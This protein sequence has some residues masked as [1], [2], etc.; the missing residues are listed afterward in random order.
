MLA[1]ACQ[2]LLGD[3][4]QGC[5]GAVVAAQQL[6]QVKRECLAKIAFIE[7]QAR[8]STKAF[9]TQAQP[10]SKPFVG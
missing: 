6:F 9:A 4:S 3:N 5:I 7:R 2:K 10:I 8:L 1:I